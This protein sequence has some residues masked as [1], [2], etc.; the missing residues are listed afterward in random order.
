LRRLWGRQSRSCYGVVDD[1]R[2]TRNTACSLR[3]ATGAKPAEADTNLRLRRLWGRQSRSCCGVP[4][5]TVSRGIQRA[6]CGAP[7]VP[8]RLR[9][10]LTCACAGYGDAKVGHAVA[11]R[12]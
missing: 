2:F 6:A 9:R 1:G 8:S 4:T 11:Y 10:T 3:G 7:R 5:M 12:R